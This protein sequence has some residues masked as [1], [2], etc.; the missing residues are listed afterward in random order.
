MD[1]NFL[2]YLQ[3]MN[4]TD[5]LSALMLISCWQLNHQAAF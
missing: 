4:K 1:S 3:F 2:G 5:H